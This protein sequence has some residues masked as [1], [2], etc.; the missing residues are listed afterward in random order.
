M[1][2]N[3]DNKK[4]IVEKNKVNN[5]IRFILFSLITNNSKPPIIG[6][7]SNKLSIGKLR[8]LIV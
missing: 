7:Q 2:K 8:I 4:V 5:L 6:V 1:N 3:I